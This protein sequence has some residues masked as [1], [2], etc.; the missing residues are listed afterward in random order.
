[1]NEVGV[2]HCASLVDDCHRGDQIRSGNSCTLIPADL[3]ADPRDF[4]DNDERR[5]PVVSAEFVEC[6]EK[7]NHQGAGLLSHLVFSEFK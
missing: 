3:P 7:S 2:S 5:R 6:D 1:M 4:D